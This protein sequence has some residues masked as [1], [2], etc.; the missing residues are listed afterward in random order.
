MNCVRLLL[1]A[2]LV[3]ATALAGMISARSCTAAEVIASEQFDASVN[4][5]SFTQDP[6]LDDV[7]GNWATGDW[8]GPLDPLSPPTVGIPFAIADDSASTSPDDELGVVDNSPDSNATA[9]TSGYKSD[10][11]FGVVDLENPNFTGTAK[12]TW[13]FDISTASQLTEVSIDMGAMGDFETA[14]DRFDWSYQI[15]AGPRVPLF[16]SSVD[17]DGEATYVMA[18]GT[19]IPLPDPLLINGEQLLTEKIAPSG[20]PTRTAAIAGSGSQLTLYFEAE[21]DGGS[22]SYEFDNILILGESGG[23]VQL[24]D[25]NLDGVVNG[26]DV[27]PFVD[28]L[29]NGPYQIQADMNEDGV[30]NGLDVD[31]FVAAVVGGGVRAI[32]EPST[33]VLL[34]AGLLAAGLI[35]GTAAFCRDGQ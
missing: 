28:V 5:V 21:A 26:L 9:F 23:A 1:C 19:Q 11:C 2:V 6:P 16:T 24:G 13:V 20:L 14:N 34:V 10:V 33:W 31:P 3:S 8:F 12:A 25:V 32:P 22:E 27:D 18:N 7:A 30:V 4:R 29:L 35:R 17:E 15:D